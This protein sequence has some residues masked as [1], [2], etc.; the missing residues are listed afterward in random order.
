MNSVILAIWGVLLFGGTGLCIV[1]GMMG[2][3]EIIASTGKR[4]LSHAGK[5]YKKRDPVEKPLNNETFL[6]FIDGKLVGIF[7][8]FD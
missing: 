2:L 6:H 1:F 4:Y 3:M 7:D 8:R 5:M